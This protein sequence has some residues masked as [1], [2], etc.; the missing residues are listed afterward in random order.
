VGDQP[1]LIH[2]HV[3]EHQNGK[4]EGPEGQVLYPSNTKKFCDLAFQLH[5]LFLVS[6]N[7][8]TKNSAVSFI[9]SVN[10]GNSSVILLCG[11]VNKRKLK[12]PLLSDETFTIECLLTCIKS[13]LFGHG[14]FRMALKN[15]FYTDEI[16]P[17]AD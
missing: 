5:S 8:I 4:K 1:F 11:P 17:L 16:Q 2:F 10:R 3:S 12:N 6:F 9:L 15:K 14:A 7:E 13:G